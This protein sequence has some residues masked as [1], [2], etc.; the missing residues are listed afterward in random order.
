MKGTNLINAQFKE[1]NMKIIWNKLNW[2]QSRRIPAD[3]TELTRILNLE[4][5]QRRIVMVHFHE[6]QLHGNTRLTVAGAL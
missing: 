5:A 2:R 3:L 6:F 4:P 1:R